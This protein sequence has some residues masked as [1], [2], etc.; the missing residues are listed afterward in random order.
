MT[1]ADQVGKRE[2]TYVNWPGKMDIYRDKEFPLFPLSGKESPNQPYYSLFHCHPDFQG[3]LLFDNFRRRVHLV[4]RQHNE[5]ELPRSV[6]LGGC[7]GEGAARHRA[8]HRAGSSTFDIFTL[9]V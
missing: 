4:C 6:R 8:R 3:H 2:S 5:Q 1:I 9:I 7:A